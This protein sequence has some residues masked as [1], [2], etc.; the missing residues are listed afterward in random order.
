M[1]CDSYHFDLLINEDK[2]CYNFFC[3]HLNVNVCNILPTILF[4]FI[5]F[6][7]QSWVS[8]FIFLYGLSPGHCL[9]WCMRS[10]WQTFV[11]YVL[12][13]KCLVPDPEAEVGGE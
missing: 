11:E 9:F 8:V 10:A 3:Y 12:C 4:Y 13:T 7:E 6:G 1:T 2:E 5:L